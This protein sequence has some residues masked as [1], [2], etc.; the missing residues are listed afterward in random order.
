MARLGSYYS[1]RQAGEG[2]EELATKL[3]GRKLGLSHFSFR[4]SLSLNPMSTF[5]NGLLRFFPAWSRILGCIL[6]HLFLGTCCVHPCLAFQDTNQSQIES[7]GQGTGDAGDTAPTSEDI[8][9]MES[10]ITSLESGGSS[11]ESG[12]TAS[13]S[14]DGDM[15]ASSLTSA[16][17]PIPRDFFSSNRPIIALSA[18][19]LTI[20][21][22]MIGLRFH[23]FV[24]LILAA[25]VVSLFASGIGSE[26]VTRVSE[27]FGTST[28]KVGIVIAMAAIIGKCMLDSGAANRIV[29]ACLSVFGVKRAPVAMAGAAFLLGIPVFFDTVFYLLVPLARSL[30][31]KTKRNYL[32]FLLAVAAGGAVTHTLVPPT[33]GPLLI[34]S[35]LNVNLGMMM[36]AGVAVGIPCSMA[37]LFFARL[38]DIRMPIEMRPLSSNDV[39]LPEPV[40]PP[41]LAWSLAPIVIPVLLITTSTVVDLIAD[42]QNTAAVLEGDINAE[43]L[44]NEIQQGLEG[45]PEKAALIR[46]LIENNSTTLGNA[47]QNAET[48]IVIADWNQQLSQPSFV[49]PSDYQYVRLDAETQSLLNGL[50]GTTTPART[51]HANRT[52]LEK[53]FPNSIRPH[54]WETPLRRTATWL[55]LPGTPSFA[56]TLAALLSIFLLWKSQRLSFQELGNSMET[57]LLSGAVIILITAAGG[58]FGD[59]LRLVNI[60]LWVKE[61]FDGITSNGASVVLL[62][63][64]I[65]AALKL[66]QGSSTVAMIGTAGMIG[67]ILGD[68]TSPVHLAYVATAIG[69]GS[70]MGSWMNDSGFWIFAKMGGLT[71]KETLKSWSILLAI[72]SLAG[73]GATL[74]YATFFPMQTS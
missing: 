70:L 62:A 56:L 64:G 39:A 23:A 61:R 26:Y 49:D 37:G 24:A 17:I 51:L 69:S 68:A 60:D 45:E 5:S 28:H 30:Y 12:G 21:I 1:T 25:F 50:S 16:D 41:N 59:M 2:H 34:A 48:P 10:A 46:K 13:E 33:P 66:A 44:S 19:V 55:A 43:T 52:F 35:T 27:S 9:A 53:L 71:E 15:G 18:G 72:L 40:N 14:T 22:L 54:T 8:E 67:A 74:L 47:W 65:A 29:D 57:A 31:T 6:L 36:L 32:R 58:A 63:W 42:Q 11:M 73:L 38:C 4:G 20:L 3:A 7:G